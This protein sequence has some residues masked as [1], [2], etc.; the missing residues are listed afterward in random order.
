MGSRSVQ[1]KARFEGNIKQEVAQDIWKDIQS[2]LYECSVCLV[3]G[4]EKLLKD[5]NQDE[6]G[7][8]LTPLPQA[9]SEALHQSDEAPE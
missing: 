6:K 7:G 2:G 5:W 4:S 8:L 3:F 9:L 1:V